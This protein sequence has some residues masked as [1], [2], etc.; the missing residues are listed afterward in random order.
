MDIILILLISIVLILSILAIWGLCQYKKLSSA[1]L[2]ILL[3]TLLIAGCQAEEISVLEDPPFMEIPPSILED[4]P[5]SVLP[6]DIPDEMGPEQPLI[7]PE[8][9]QKASIII[10]FYSDCLWE[11]REF[12]QTAFDLEWARLLNGT[13]LTF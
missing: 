3:L 4:P 9:M 12:N 5:F 11:D 1:L 13:N 8:P 10:T 6:P 7:F 2:K